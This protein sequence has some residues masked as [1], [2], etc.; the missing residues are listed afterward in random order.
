[1]NGDFYDPSWGPYGDR[2]YVA[3][4]FPD[5][6]A[7]PLSYYTAIQYLDLAEGWQTSGLPGSFESNGKELFSMQNYLRHPVS[8]IMADGREYLA[9]EKTL[10]VY[11]ACEYIYLIDV[12]SCA[13]GETCIQDPEFAGSMPSWTKDGRLIHGYG[14]W[15]ATGSCAITEV[16]VWDGSNDTLRSLLD[17]TDPDAAGGWSE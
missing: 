17:G 12:D 16:G 3:R 7:S 2:I 13:A 1:V 10:T 5:P 15:E 4:I 14:G 11:E 6:G 9:V 8:G